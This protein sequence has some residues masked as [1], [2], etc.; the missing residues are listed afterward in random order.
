MFQSES[1]CT[2]RSGRRNDRDVDT[3]YPSVVRQND[4]GRPRR[5]EAVSGFAQRVSIA[6]LV[7]FAAADGAWIV[8]EAVAKSRVVAVA[9]PPVP[10]T[11]SV[12]KTLAST[13]TTPVYDGLYADA[14]DAAV[15][16][17]I[18]RESNEPTS[19]TTVAPGEPAGSW[20]RISAACASRPDPTD[21]DVTSRLRT[22]ATAGSI[23]AQRALV[24]NQVYQ[25]EA[26]VD[27]VMTESTVD[28][29]KVHNYYDP[30][31]QALRTLGLRGDRVAAHVM[32]NVLENGKL[33]ERD[34]AM[35]AAWKIVADQ[36]A[37]QAMPNDEVLQRNLH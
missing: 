10:Y 18:R 28:Q 17:Q 19:A 12:S 27:A 4:A 16:R 23:D 20:H 2:G 13:T 31:V 22:A 15:C 7:F 30:D 9:A 21:G 26:D 11:Q 5:P 33:V 36:G 34:A 1:N 8:H 14:R 32:A 3:Q 25:D 29:E 6:L 35:A 37:E 24:I